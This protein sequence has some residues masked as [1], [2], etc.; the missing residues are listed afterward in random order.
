MRFVV[1]LVIVCLLAET[2][3][4]M[5]AESDDGPGGSF[6]VS[7]RPALG[8][9]LGVTGNGDHNSG[10]GSSERAIAFDTPV[11][12]GWRQRA[13]AARTAWLFG[14]RN[15]PAYQLVPNNVVTMKNINV[16]VLLVRHAGPRTAGYAGIGYGSYHY[17]YR[18]GAVSSPWRGGSHGQCLRRR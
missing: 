14:V 16:S 13:D 7:E 10:D 6:A 12:V 11:D 15:P 17:A 9:F 2:A 3:A 18:Y 5:A 4:V 8:V 1:S